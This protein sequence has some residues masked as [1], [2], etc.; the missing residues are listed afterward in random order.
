M[1]RRFSPD[2]INSNDPKYKVETF[3]DPNK[4]LFKKRTE[5]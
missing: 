4:T 2:K 3:I 5:V 1:H